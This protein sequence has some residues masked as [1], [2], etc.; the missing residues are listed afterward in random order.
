MKQKL[1]FAIIKLF[2]YLDHGRYELANSKVD[3]T[4]EHWGKWIYG[5][6]H[7]VLG[8]G[9]RESI[10]QKWYEGLREEVAEVDALISEKITA[11]PTFINNWTCGHH[12]DD[13]TPAVT[14]LSR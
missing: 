3:H 10:A 11:L 7:Y 8:C 6:S 14:G 2:L 9:N 12:K 4:Q 13:V 1:L 5:L